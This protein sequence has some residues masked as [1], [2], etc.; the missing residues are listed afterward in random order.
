MG[1]DPVRATGAPLGP[2]P[3]L[4]EDETRA[5][6]A[7]IG[8]PYGAPVPVSAVRPCRDG[9][10]KL[11]PAVDPDSQRGRRSLV[12]EVHARNPQV[13]C[14]VTG[15]PELQL[16]GADDRPLPF[17]VVGDTVSPIA[18]VLVTQERTPAARVLVSQPT[19][20]STDVARASS[21]RVTLPGESVSTLVE[22]PD[23][24]TLEYCVG[25]SGDPGVTVTESP[26]LAVP[27]GGAPAP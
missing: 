13:R 27:P 21:L 8:N 22:V 9:D 3:F 23:G 7:A 5:L 17:T 10:V 20:R 14:T 26:F 24:L 12:V 11:I 16:L 15:T 2:E 6:L 4:D 1:P 19:C 25:G 18:A